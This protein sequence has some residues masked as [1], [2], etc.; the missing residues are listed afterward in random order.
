M[1]TSDLSA[2]LS[3]LEADRYE[4]PDGRN[5]DE[6]LEATIEDATNSDGT[7]EESKEYLHGRGPENLPIDLYDALQIL[8]V[9]GH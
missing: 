9:D 8:A 3:S 6:I 4:S 5:V 7:T 1:A 2:D